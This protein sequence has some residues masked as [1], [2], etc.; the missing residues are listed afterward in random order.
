MAASDFYDDVYTMF[1]GYF[2]RPPAQA[3]LDYYAQQLD[4]YANELLDQ[5]QPVDDAWKLLADDM[6][7]S[8]EGQELYGDLGLSAQIIQ[9]YQFTF[10]RDPATAGLDYWTDAVINGPVDEATGERKDPVPVAFIPYTIAKSADADDTAVLDAKIASAELWVASLDTPQEIAAFETPE[11]RDAGRQ[12]LATVTTDQPADQAAADAAIAEMVNPTPVGQTFTLTTAAD[13]IPGLVGD[14]GTTNTDGD[15]TIVAT[16]TT[17]SAADRIADAGGENEL[18]YG[19]SGTL[20]NQVEIGAFQMSGVQTLTATNDS[21]QQVRFDLSGTSDLALVK[22]L[23]SSANVVFDELTTLADV[24]VESATTNANVRVQFQNALLTGADDTVNL[25]LSATNRTNSDIGTITLGSVA[26]VNRGIENL[27]IEVMGADTTVNGINSD[28]TNVVITGDGSSLTL[29][30]GSSLTNDGYFNATLRS[31]DA[32]SYSGSL[33]LGVGA[34]DPTLFPNDPSAP[35]ESTL[36]TA[37][38]GSGND[39]L[40]VAGGQLDSALNDGDD[41]M[42]F[43]TALNE[44]NNHGFRADD[45]ID[46]GA[47]VDTLQ[48]GFFNGAVLAGAID[49][50]TGLPIGPVGGGFTLSTTEFNNK[51]GF[52]VIDVRAATTNMTLSQGFIDRMT[53][54]QG[55]LLVTSDRVNDGFTGALLVAANIAEQGMVTTL[56][57]TALSQNTPLNYVGGDGSD[58]LVLNNDTFNNEVTLDG[59][60]SWNADATP[61]ITGDYDTLTVVGGS[62]QTVIDASDLSNVSNF[63]GLNLVKQGGT[64]TFNLEL[65]QGFLNA[66][67]ENANDLGNTT[68]V[69]DQVFQIFSETSQNGNA[70]GIGDTVNIDITGLV[71]VNLGGRGFDFTDLNASGATVNYTVSGTVLAATDPRIA[72]VTTVDSNQGRNDVIAS[73]ANPSSQQQ[74]V[75]VAQASGFDTTSGFQIQN[76]TVATAGDDLLRADAAFLDATATIDLGNGFDT[77]E[78]TTAVATPPLT[79]RVNQALNITQNVEKFV[80][81]AGSAFNVNITNGAGIA[82]E[83]QAASTVTLGAGGQT[84]TSTAGAQVVNAGGGND[85][86]TTGVS[87]DVISDNLGSE[88]IDSGAGNDVVFIG[89]G[90]ETVTLGAGNDQL[91]VVVAGT[92][93]ID[94]DEPADDT[95]S[96][97]TIYL[98]NTD[99]VAQAH[100]AQANISNFST[101]VGDGV[102]DVLVMASARGGVM[103]TTSD[104]VYLNDATGVG[105]P[106]V[107][108]LGDGTVLEIASSAYQWSGTAPNE[109]A[110]QAFMENTMG[111]TG[112]ANAVITVVA[113][114]ASAD[115]NAA[116]LQ[117]WNNDADAAFDEVEL[118]AVLDGVGIDALTAANFA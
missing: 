15:D 5:G 43:D 45:S 67:T 110:L 13:T 81:T 70:L 6:F 106:L 9:V 61:A 78:I 93:T 32:E 59:G 21:D 4:Q 71:G 18:F 3:G 16:N 101:A 28:V 77:L 102:D 66:N 44:T 10:G 1:V 51:Q 53:E 88:T 11:G 12:F 109:A 23:N 91:F 7:K 96:V 73:R 27:N 99:G 108:N 35:S 103:V 118:V 22:S 111:V 97:D 60:S 68:N 65:T 36:L 63:E 84:F 94:A 107:T 117:A 24:E 90:N 105:A 47:G 33:N 50:V 40:W 58:R 113:Y 54:D 38:T 34:D 19:Q 87:G 52:E 79:A 116:V 25:D 48:L 17:L 85:N 75:L 29:G 42:V 8:A 26:T 49:P 83:A 72:A 69:N 89:A 112:V 39:V 57:T 31:L 20:A 76:S 104:G 82:T 64:S 86:I 98:S 2:G 74:N 95:T 62:A 55:P 46:G 14:Q 41:T 56:D 115:G 92:D 30:D 114:D 37:K 80:L 100:T